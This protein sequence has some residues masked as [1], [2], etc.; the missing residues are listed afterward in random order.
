MYYCFCSSLCVLLNTSV[1]SMVGDVNLF[2]S[3]V[4]GCRSAE[5][6]I[7]IAQQSSHGKGLGLEA[8]LAMMSYGKVFT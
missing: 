6:E 2:L 3:E 1:G 5:I 4:D 7:M 8:T